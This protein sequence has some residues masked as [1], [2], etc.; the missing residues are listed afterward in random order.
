ME[1]ILYLGLIVVVMPLV[2]M[3]AYF[4]V[5]A[6]ARSQDTD[7]ILAEGNKVIRVVGQT[8]RNATKINDP[9]L[10]MT[11]D[12]LSLAVDDAGKNPVVFKIANGRLVKSEGP[13]PL[14]E[15]TSS[16]IAINQIAFANTSQPG[17]PGTVTFDFTLASVIF[18]KN[19]HATASLR[20]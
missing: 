9:I 19:F 4:S 6:R 18:S 2:A 17:T 13:G 14:V 12:S 10:G 1:V 5:G 3:L 15:L 11:S 16:R 8:I 7:L 20:Y